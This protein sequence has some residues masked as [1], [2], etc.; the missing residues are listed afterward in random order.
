MPKRPYLTIMDPSTATVARTLARMPLRMESA[1]RS[2]PTV[3]SSTTV[4]ATGSLPERSAM[5]RSLALATVK[6]PEICD[7]PQRIG[8]LMLGA[9][10]TTPLRMIANDRLKFYIVHRATLRPPAPTKRQVP[11]G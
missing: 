11:N 3:R 10:R 9:E 4:N 1:P 7:E 6:L 8:S 2:G 5:E